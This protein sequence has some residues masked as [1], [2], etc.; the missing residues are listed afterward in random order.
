MSDIHPQLSADCVVLGQL[1]LCHLLLMNDCH[2]PW[3]ILVP[4]RAGLREIFQLDAGDRR[5]LLHESCE[6]SE[7]LM[8]AYSGDKLNVAALGNLVP[9]LHL[10]H[11]VRYTADPAW[12]APVWGRHP[13]EP[14]T[15]PAIDEIRTLLSRAGLGGYAPAVDA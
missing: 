10:H 14:Y 8:E 1:P 11:I 15:P 13:A 2:Y 9:Q 7:F 4:R 3:F 6:L 12:P 5:Q